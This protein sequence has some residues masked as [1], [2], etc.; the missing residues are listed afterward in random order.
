MKAM[1]CSELGGAC[2]LEFRAETF[3]EMRALSQT[4]GKAMFGEQDADHLAAMQKMQD[5]MQTPGA[6]DEWMAGR[7]AAFNALP[8]IEA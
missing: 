4:H 7:E 1:K 8:D 5:M 2:D 3:D 6:V